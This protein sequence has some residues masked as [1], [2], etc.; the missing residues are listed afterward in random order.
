MEE[1]QWARLGGWCRL[2]WHLQPPP[3]S[4]CTC[5]VTQGHLGCVQSTKESVCSRHKGESGVWGVH[6]GVVLHTTSVPLCPCWG[7][8]PGLPSCP[9]GQS[10][11]WDVLIIVFQ[12]SRLHSQST[13]M[14]VLLLQFDV[15]MKSDRGNPLKWNCDF[16]YTSS[17]KQ[18]HLWLG[19]RI[20]FSVFACVYSLCSRRSVNQ[21]RSFRC[22]DSTTPH[23]HLWEGVFKKFWEINNVKNLCMDFKECAPK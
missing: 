7:Q 4:S 6:S 3:P 20:N 11:S 23:P 9:S 16:Y 17:T 21:R 15:L 13:T 18:V 10:H 12:W 22:W 2:R 8:A 5:L 14:V 19:R 1:M